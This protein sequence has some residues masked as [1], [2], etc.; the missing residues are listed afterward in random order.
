MN[1]WDSCEIDIVSLINEKSVQL[2]KQC[3]KLWNTS[4]S[5]KISSSEWNILAL[6]QKQEHSVSEIARLVNITRQAA[7]KCLKGMHAK[8]LIEIVFHPHN[9]R[10]RYFVLTPYGDQCRA[11]YSAIKRQLEDKIALTIGTENVHVIKAHLCKDWCC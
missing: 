5:I 9:K 1:S 4:Q 3:E 11:E 6:L 8:G 10:N 2:R 7:Y